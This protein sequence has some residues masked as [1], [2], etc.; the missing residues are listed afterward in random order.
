LVVRRL[1]TGAVGEQLFAIDPH[2][3][4]VVQLTPARG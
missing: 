4:R 1:Q 3:I 2:A